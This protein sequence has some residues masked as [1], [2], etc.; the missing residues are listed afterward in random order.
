MPFTVQWICILLI[1]LGRGTVLCGTSNDGN[2]VSSL[3]LGAFRME[4]LVV[5]STT[6][7]WIYSMIAVST[8]AFERLYFDVV[9]LLLMLIETGNL[10]SG[11]FYRK[12]HQRVSSLSLQLP[13]KARINEMQFLR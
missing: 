3:R 1:I 2:G 4:S 12:L 9:T 10:G 8:G 5:V 13:K 11:S 7:A 6:I